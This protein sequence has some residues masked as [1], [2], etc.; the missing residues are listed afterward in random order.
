M[1]ERP[2]VVR[3]RKQDLPSLQRAVKRRVTQPAMPLAMKL[4]N[5]LSVEEV[6]AAIQRHPE[7][8]RRQARDGRLPGEKIGR[9]WFFRPERL[10]EAGFSQFLARLAGDSGGGRPGEPP[11]TPL[12]RALGEAGL[13][14]LQHL[15]RRA[16]FEAVGS[17]LAGAG[18]S[19]HLFH[20]K[21]D[22]KGLTIAFVHALPGAAEVAKL[23]GREEVG[24]FIPFDRIPILQKACSTLKPQYI[25]DY[26][27]LVGRVAMVLRPEATANARRLGELLQMHTVI[28]APLVIGD[29]AIGAITVIGP[30]LR[31]SDLPPVMA[32]ANQTAAALETA[33]LL[34]ESR[35]MEEAMVLTLAGAVE[36]RE[37]LHNRADEHAALAERFAEHLG[38][39]SARRRRV[40]YA[41]LLQ[42]LGKINLPD[43]ILRK[44]GRLD[45]E[46]RA[47]MMTH[48]V[49]AADVLRRFKPLAD[50]ALLVR[51]HHEWFNGEGYPDG[52]KGEA[53]PI[54]TRIISI[55]NAFF[56]VTFDLPTK[57]EQTVAEGLEELTRFGGINLDPNVTEAFVVMC[58]EAESNQRPWYRQL[59][60]KLFSSHSAPAAVTDIL[61]VADSREL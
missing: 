17:R 49:V 7:V 48:P 39:D 26:D 36:L 55:V 34:E 59:M 27:E 54:E 51:A 2:L 25:G 58:R 56:N 61:S 12:V 1:G 47:L 18:L 40:R 22:S 52:L 38:F 9:V 42:D 8:V 37:A 31:E 53:I 45:A 16:I 14:A 43:T 57:T 33:R 29:R 6:A 28:S 35:E 5:L 13:Q 23:T 20:C 46:E 30:G 21:P 10:V 3:R 24:A 60:E 44:R 19:T 41:A 4:P 11:V 50:L 15:D 32:F